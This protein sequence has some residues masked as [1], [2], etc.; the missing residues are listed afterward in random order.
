MSEALHEVLLESPL[1]LQNL[2]PTRTN[3][4]RLIRK[5]LNHCVKPLMLWQLRFCPGFAPHGRYEG[6]GEKGIPRHCACRRAN[7]PREGAVAAKGTRHR[8]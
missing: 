5:K 3:Y 6:G 4:A 1:G 8:R 7:L 2:P